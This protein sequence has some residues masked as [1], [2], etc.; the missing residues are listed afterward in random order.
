MNTKKLINTSIFCFKLKNS[1]I[2]IPLGCGGYI[3]G[4]GV[5]STQNY[6]SKSIADCFW[7]IESWNS[8]DSFLLRNSFDKK[9]S[10]MTLLSEL[11]F[12]TMIVSLMCF[13][14]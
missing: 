8:E 3:N 6:S 10:Q 2:K 4:D 14:L 11:I 1:F 13:N 9:T 7:F 5:I 12:P